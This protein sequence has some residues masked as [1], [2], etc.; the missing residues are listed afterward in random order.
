MC[1]HSCLQQDCCRH[2]RIGGVTL[3]YCSFCRQA[4]AI[5]ASMGWISHYSVCPKYGE[6][7]EKLEGA[8]DVDAILKKGGYK[9]KDG[10]CIP[11]DNK[12]K[13]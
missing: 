2:K 6:E 9:M 12:H 4:V 3:Q 11:I 1:G 8:L 5:S 10:K 13:L 7:L